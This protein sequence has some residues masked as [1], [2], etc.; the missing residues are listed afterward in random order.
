[1]LVADTQLSGAR[2]VQELTDLI[3]QRGKP[4]LLVSDTRTELTSSAILR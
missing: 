3:G 2:M 4:T 1:V